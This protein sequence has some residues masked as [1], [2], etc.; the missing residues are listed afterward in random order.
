[1]R[2]IGADADYCDSTVRLAC[3]AL[4]MSGFSPP[5]TKRTG[6]SRRARQH[7]GRRSPPGAFRHRR[8]KTDS[9]L[10]VNETPCSTTE[11]TVTKYASRYWAVWL[12]GE[13]V[14]VTLY[15][16]GAFR[17]AELLQRQKF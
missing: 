7:R 11:V 16:K 9:G 3:A 17:V 15:R 6:Y 5:A 1:M 13:L 10:F 2:E 14:A 4:S 12:S 8:G